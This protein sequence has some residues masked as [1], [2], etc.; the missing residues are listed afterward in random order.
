MLSYLAWIGVNHSLN[1]SQ[2]KVHLQ[3]D[4]KTL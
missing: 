4:E 2:A 1:A 3:A